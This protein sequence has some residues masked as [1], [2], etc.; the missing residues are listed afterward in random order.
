MELNCGFKDLDWNESKTK[1]GTGVKYVEV[2][3]CR[4]I[5]EVQAGHTIKGQ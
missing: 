5:C 2:R 3:C 1:I 4:D